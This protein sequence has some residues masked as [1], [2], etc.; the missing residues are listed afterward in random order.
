MGAVPLVRGPETT[1]I[2]KCEDGG[3]ISLITK[4]GISKKEELLRL[5]SKT[6]LDDR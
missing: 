6:R 3:T 5:T 1:R 2:T 4:R